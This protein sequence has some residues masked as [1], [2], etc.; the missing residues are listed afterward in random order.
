M[1]VESIS[2]CRPSELVRYTTWTSRISWRLHSALKS[3]Q[4]Q[5]NLQRLNKTRGLP[6]G[7]SKQALDGQAKLNR[8]GS[9]NC[10]LRL[11]LAR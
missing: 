2:K 5:Q 10:G 8:S 6:Q 7:Q 9:E 3:R 11:C 1:P 4:H